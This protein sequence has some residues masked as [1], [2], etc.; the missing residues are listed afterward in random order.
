M[1]FSQHSDQANLSRNQK[2]KVKSH[3]K[4]Q[5]LH[6]ID[7]VVYRQGGIEN[8]Q[9][10]VHSILREE[11]LTHMHDSQVSGH[12]GSHHTIHRTARR[13]WWPGMTKDII[14]WIK[15]CQEC[16]TRNAS[17]RQRQRIP[18]IDFDAP[19]AFDR[20]AVDVQGK[21]PESRNGNKYI[22]TFIETSTRWTEGFAVPEVSGKAIAEL[23]VNKV[24]LVHG[25]VR[26]LL[27]DRGSNFLSEIVVETC[28][29]LNIQ[30]VTTSAYHPQ[31]NGNVER[32]HGIYN[33]VISKYVNTSH[34]DWDVCFPFAQHAYR[35][36]V[37][38]VLGES[39][40]Y[41]MHGRDPI[42]LPD[43]SLLPGAQS[44]DFDVRQYIAKLTDRVTQAR[45]S[46]ARMHMAAKE[47]LLKNSSTAEPRSFTLGERVMIRNE[48]IVNNEDLGRKWQPKWIGPYRVT[49]QNGISY[50]LQR[51]D[52]TS[53]MRVRNIDDLK[54]YFERALRP[55]ASLADLPVTGQS[56][57]WNT[58][59]ED[60]TEVEK[61][62]DK[63]IR[64]LQGRRNEV[65]YLVRW[66]NFDN[67]HDEWLTNKELNC[68]DLIKEY[69]AS[70]E[71]PPTAVNVRR[72]QRKQ[73]KIIRR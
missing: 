1:E 22:V 54:P 38:S 23:L 48:T 41:L 50:T 3:I 18:V 19:Q 66:K 47:N 55:P 11:I 37:H 60:E 45:K 46:A 39:P 12:L 6:M 32:I 59:T 10:F 67:T 16:L 5:R 64:L 43:V 58:L 71:D 15:S 69:D 26:S 70:H 21:F 31:T 4:A 35:T 30:K 8:R 44:T 68:P 65:E 29:L 56:H 36:S 28:K 14:T 53:D 63:R 72:S 62:L 33:S 34:D 20:V 13:Y 9:L 25:G 2:N 51:C 24:I 7:D 17:P 52:D 42:D 27:S 49:K 73:A 61:I 40:Y 57:G